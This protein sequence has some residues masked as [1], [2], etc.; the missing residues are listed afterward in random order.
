MATDT[1]C[2]EVRK[3]LANADLASMTSRRVRTEV[4]KNL[5][6]GDMRPYRELVEVRCSQC[7]DS[8]Q[9]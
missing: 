2:A 4:G 7:S 9:G 5:K 8:V 1:I 6:I 3:I